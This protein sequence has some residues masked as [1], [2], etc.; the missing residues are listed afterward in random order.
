MDI[1]LIIRKVL[2]DGRLSIY[3]RTKFDSFT[4]SRRVITP[5]TEKELKYFLF[6][7]KALKKGINFSSFTKNRVLT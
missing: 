5:C 7:N 3:Y 6:S 1:S 4:S 2:G